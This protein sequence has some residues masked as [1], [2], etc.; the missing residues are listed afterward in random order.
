MDV[1]CL[2]KFSDLTLVG[3]FCGDRVTIMKYKQ[4]GNLVSTIVLPQSIVSLLDNIE[5]VINDNVNSY[6]AM[7]RDSHISLGTFSVSMFE[8][9]D[10]V[11]KGSSLDGGGFFGPTKSSVSSRGLMGEIVP[12]KLV[13]QDVFESNCF[14]K[15]LI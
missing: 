4:G 3:K 12:D 1:G 6:K 2:R 13:I 14:W 11:L 8:V 5:G 7:C 10:D 9:G 15:R